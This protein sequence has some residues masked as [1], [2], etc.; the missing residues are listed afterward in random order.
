MKSRPTA[1]RAAFVED[2]NEQLSPGPGAGNVGPFGESQDVGLPG[3][4]D[5]DGEQW[6]GTLPR[7]FGQSN[8]DALLDSGHRTA[9]VVQ[10]QPNH[11][12]RGE[13]HRL[14]ASR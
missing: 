8:D 12:R 14:G 1:M 11:L 5:L 4:T 9:Q 6:P 7:G 10:V 2:G 13:R 3:F